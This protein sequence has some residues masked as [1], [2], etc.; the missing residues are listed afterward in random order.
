MNHYKTFKIVS[1]LSL[2]NRCLD[3]NM[4][5]QLSKKFLEF[6]IKTIEDFFPCSHNLIMTH[7]SYANPLLNLALA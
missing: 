5:T 7:E 4:Q 1:I 3:K 2:D 6:F